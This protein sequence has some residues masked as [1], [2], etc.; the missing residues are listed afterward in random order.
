VCRNEEKQKR[1]IL[2]GVVDLDPWEFE[3]GMA[4]SL[5]EGERDVQAMGGLKCAKKRSLISRRTASRLAKENK[6]LILV[7]GAV[8]QGRGG[9]DQ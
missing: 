4:Q 5:Q 6:S 3:K 9:T 1:R 7:K 2:R 8:A